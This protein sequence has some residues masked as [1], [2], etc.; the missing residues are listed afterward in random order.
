M[1]QRRIDANN[2][3]RAA[4]DVEEVMIVGPD[5]APYQ[6][7]DSSGV[8]A[9]ASFTPTAAAYSA[10]DIM[11]ASV[12]FDF[13]Y[14]AS[15]L[16]VPNTAMIRIL[17]A[18]TRIDATE[19][20]ASEGAYQLQCYAVTQPSAQA[21]NDA[22]TLASGDLA[23]YRGVVG[24]GTPV[25]LGAACYVRSQGVDQDVRLATGSMWARL[26]TLAAFTPTAVARQITLYGI[27]L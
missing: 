7:G 18:I 6:G 9:T 15:G 5:G 25:D 16:A 26:Q 20:Q 1:A 23:S 13:T 21:D 10:N 19:L 12:E 8:I 2:L 14:A 24:L 3:T 11:G 27:V 17:T 4:V 22:W